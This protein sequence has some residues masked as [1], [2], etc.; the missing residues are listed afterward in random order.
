MKLDKLS[1]GAIVVIVIYAVIGF[2]FVAT[3]GNQY[4][5][6]TTVTTRLQILG[7]WPYYLLTEKW[8]T[9]TAGNQAI[10]LVRPPIAM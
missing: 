1:T 5:T 3:K 9:D 2:V 8:P 4:N 6:V 7:L 10:G